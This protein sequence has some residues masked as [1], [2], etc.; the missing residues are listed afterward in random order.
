MPMGFLCTMLV[1]IP[2]G[3]LIGAVILRGAVS[4]TNS[5]L[6]SSGSRRYDYYDDDDD[7]E[8]YPTPRR[9]SRSGGAVP[10]PSIGKGMLIG[11]I[12]LIV[13]SVLGFMIN[14]VFGRGVAAANANAMGAAIMSQLISIPVC[15]LVVATLLSALLPTTFG[16]AC[17]VALFYILIVIAIAAVI[18]GT[19]FFMWGMAFRGGA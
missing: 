16:K 1:G 12:I 14:F 2:I 10:S 4:I 19:L 5:V 3:L 9:R 7:D 8:Y 6:G 11:F 18:F 13:Q 17:L 15:F